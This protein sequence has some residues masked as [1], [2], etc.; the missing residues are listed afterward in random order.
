MATDVMHYPTAPTR[1]EDRDSSRCSARD[2]HVDPAL[3]SF[4]ERVIVTALVAR[5]IAAC[6]R[7]PRR[8]VNEPVSS[9]RPKALR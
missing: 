7:S 5:W 9:S 2:G 8:P 4:L 6:E 3:E 1:L